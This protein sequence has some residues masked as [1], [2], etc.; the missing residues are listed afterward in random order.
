MRDALSVVESGTNESMSAVV[1]AAI[2]YFLEREWPDALR[3][4]GI[5]VTGRRSRA[6]GSRAV[7]LAE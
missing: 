6:R 5:E 2:L 7:A 4:A 1:R 3:A